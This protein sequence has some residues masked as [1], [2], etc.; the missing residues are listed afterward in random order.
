MLWI[1]IP[2]YNRKQFTRRCLLSLQAQTVSAFRIVVIDDGSTDG[3]GEMLVNEFPDVTVLQGSGN[4]F[5]TAA[6]NM[7]ISHALA[8]D[9]E[10]ILTLNND[11]APAPDFIEKMLTRAYENSGSILSS[12]E[13]DI[14]TGKPV[15][16]GELV[17]WTWGGTT[18]LLDTIPIHARKGL[19]EVSVA[20]GRGLLVPST[21][22]REIGLFNEKQLPH[23]LADYD[24]TCLA[25]RYGFG[26]YCNYD[27]RLYVYTEE[28]GDKEILRNKSIRNYFNHLFG[29]KGAG[30]LRYF[31]IYTVRNSPPVMV[32]LQLFIGYSKRIVNYFR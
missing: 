28:S 30:N 13:F 11:T 19:H 17:N 9:A 18:F 26:L 31:T 21:V 6:V 8:A 4:L 32:P 1:V 23:Y 16:G 10:Y 25:K 7:G 29:I 15:Y 27:A 24:F 5:W 14:Q 22:F 3:T 2:V 12:Y 20:S